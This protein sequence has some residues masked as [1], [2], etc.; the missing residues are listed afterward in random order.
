MTGYGDLGSQTGFRT[1]PYDGFSCGFNIVG[2]FIKR[3]MQWAYAGIEPIDIRSRPKKPLYSKYSV[4]N[5]IKQ[6]PP[7]SRL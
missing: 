2:R 5:K 7:H 4:L 6:T 1:A 3:V